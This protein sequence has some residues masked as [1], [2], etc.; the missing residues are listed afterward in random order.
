[1]FVARG[2]Q[3]VVHSRHR[4]A[5]RPSTSTNRRPNRRLRAVDLRTGSYT[6][7]SGTREYRL[8][9]PKRRSVGRRPLIVMLHGGNQ[10]PDDFATATRMNELAEEIGCLVVYPDQ[11]FSANPGKSWNWFNPEDQRRDMGVPALIAGITRRIIHAHPVDRHASMSVVC[12][13]VARRR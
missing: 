6:N 13:P 3:A 7:E 10:S 4:N 12:P 2:P 1:M 8:F 5:P 9:V 11:P